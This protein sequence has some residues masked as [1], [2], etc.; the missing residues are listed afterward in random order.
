MIAR[1]LLHLPGGRAPPAELQLPAFYRKHLDYRGLPIVSSGKVPDAALRAARDAVARMTAKRPG[2][3]PA[4]AQRGLR[5][6]IM[7]ES[8][9]TT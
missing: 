7:A 8:E 3:V 4:L 5:V 9:R 1:A 2:I 6:A